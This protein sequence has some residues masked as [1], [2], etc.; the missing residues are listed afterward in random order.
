[1][2]K[3]LAKPLLPPPRWRPTK[4]WAVLIGT[5]AAS[6]TAYFMLPADMNELARRTVV[7]FI[8]AA[9]F[10]A[11]EVIPLFATSL[12]VI[13]LEILLLAADGGLAP[14]GVGPNGDVSFQT[15]LEPFSSSVIILFLGGFLL[16]AAVTKHGID[17]AIGTRLLQ[18]FTRRPIVLLY[19]V[20]GITAFFSMWISNTATTAMMLA[21]V[22]PLIKDLPAEDK[23]H[24][25]LVLAVP[26][27]AN[28]GGMAT[29]IGT[30]PNAVAL[31]VL[32]EA[33]YK[34][35]FLDWMLVALPLALLLLALIGLILFAFF[36]PAGNLELPRITPPDRIELRGKVTLIIMAVTIALWLTGKLHGVNAAV[37]ALIAAAS[38][39]ALGVLNSKDVDSIDWNIL[40]LM[41]GG[42]SLGNAMLETGLVDYVVNLPISDMRGPVLA[43]AIVLLA[44]GLS[45]FISNTA[46]VNLIVPLAMAVSTTAA[47]RIQL[48][49][50]TA[51]ACSMA[52]AMPVS[53][54][55]N[56]MA[57]A[58]G[59]IPVSS[60]IRAGAVVGIVAMVALL[61]GYQFMLPL[62][63]D[64]APVPQTI[65]PPPAP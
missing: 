6:L 64:I 31:A 36:K 52:M 33:G 1:M 40:I 19:G 7:I 60:L 24:R 17:R 34:I 61:V 47:G 57:F 41:W 5:T 23:F 39:T 14:R 51:L 56:A 16:S 21:I 4:T 12:C 54:P 49:I 43:V 9:V 48:V 3:D 45:N 58:T 15:F 22:A 8:I 25:A 27:G 38:L 29:P 18:P 55:P 13:G 35:G 37:V 65:N 20:L 2:L 26:F 62:L 30:P 59:K 42:L 50:L 11:T 10:W 63:L 44:W 28:I 32:R 46:T 53:T